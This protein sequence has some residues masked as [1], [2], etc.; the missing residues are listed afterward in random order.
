MTFG[1]LVICDLSQG[2]FWKNRYEI[3][4]MGLNECGEQGSSEWTLSSHRRASKQGHNSAS[5]SGRL[6]SPPAQAFSSSFASASQSSSQRGALKQARSGHTSTENLPVSIPVSQ[7]K[8]EVLALV[9]WP[10]NPTAALFLT[11]LQS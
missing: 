8:S 10:H 9:L 7:V 6:Q 3:N 4:Q 11:Q 5:P 1:A 2:H